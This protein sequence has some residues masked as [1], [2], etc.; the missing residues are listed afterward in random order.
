MNKH[1]YPIIATLLFGLLLCTS[2]S[3]SCESHESENQEPDQN[4]RI[5]ALPIIPVTFSPAQCWPL[6]KTAFQTLYRSGDASQKNLMC[7][8]IPNSALTQPTPYQR[9]IKTIFAPWQINRIAQRTVD[10]DY[11]QWQTIQTLEGKIQFIQTLPLTPKKVACNLF[12]L[13]SCDTPKLVTIANSTLSDYVQ[14]AKTLG[15]TSVQDIS[16]LDAD[17]DNFTKTIMPLTHQILDCMVE[18]MQNNPTLPKGYTW[19]GLESVFQILYFEFCLDQQDAMKIFSNKIKLLEYY[20][21]QDPNPEHL[22]GLD[23]Y[24]TE[25]K[26]QLSAEDNLSIATLM[27]LAILKKDLQGAANCLNILH[28]FGANHQPQSFVCFE[29]P[30]L[31]YIAFPDTKTMSDD[32]V[33]T[34]DSVLIR[35]N[36]SYWAF[37]KRLQSLD[38]AIKTLFTFLGQ[39]IIQNNSPEIDS[40]TE[41]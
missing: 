41:I 20:Y 9:Q 23:E 29:E 6:L 36:P 14:L 3:Y 25:F 39:A 13:R 7:H 2:S 17:M 40:K 32:H 18:N 30:I 10:P 37:K 33:N 34:L 12:M 27:Y 28:Q 16:L 5:T 19:R 31:N 38:P 21:L 4:Q 26:L 11:Q 15:V 1:T 24:I 8:L 22:L 35:C